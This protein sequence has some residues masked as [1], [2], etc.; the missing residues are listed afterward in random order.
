MLLFSGKDPE[1]WKEGV[2]ILTVTREPTPLNSQACVFELDSTIV[3]FAN[4]PTQRT[5]SRG[6]KYN[7][8]NNK[9]S[10]RW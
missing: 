9:N 8:K 2:N 1:A 7:S 4:Q 3:F 6:S 5:E 10:H